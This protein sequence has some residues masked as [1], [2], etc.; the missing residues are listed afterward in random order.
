MIHEAHGPADP[1]PPLRPLDYG[2]RTIP[3][4]APRSQRHKR[5]K[6]RSARG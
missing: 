5:R 6:A 2:R 3:P 4:L 1:P